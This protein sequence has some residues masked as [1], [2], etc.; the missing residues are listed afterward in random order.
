MVGLCDLVDE[1]WTATLLPA[2]HD[3]VT[4]I[5]FSP[6]GSLL[7]AG[8]GTAQTLWPGEPTDL[9]LWQLENRQVRHQML[10]NRRL[11]RCLAFSP[12]GRTLATGGFDRLVLV[13]DVSTGAKRTTIDT[14]SPFN[15]MCLAFSADSGTL[16]FGTHDGSVWLADVRGDTPLRQIE[17]QD[18]TVW[19]VAYSPDGKSLAAAF[20][21]QVQGANEVATIKLWDTATTELKLRLNS[22]SN[23]PQSLVFSPDGQ[24]L[25]AGFNDGTIH[26]WCAPKQLSH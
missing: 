24:I 14:H 10:G 4:C 3:P 16:A 13:W 17:G 23:P 7:A 21:Q 6:D 22:K 19:A 18:G 1:H 26:L 5:A 2:H 25:A 9:R 12:D 20:G 15:V 8:G 11:V